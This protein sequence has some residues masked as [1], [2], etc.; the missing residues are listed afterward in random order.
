MTQNET[1]GQNKSSDGDTNCGFLDDTAVNPD[2]V[3]HPLK[4]RRV[5]LS[6]RRGSRKSHQETGEK[7]K[8]VILYVADFRTIHAHP[9]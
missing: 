4:Q 2:G 7:H 3:G 6:L 8:C 5:P 1:H 9:E